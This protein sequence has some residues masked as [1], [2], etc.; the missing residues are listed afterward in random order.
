MP[1][2]TYVRGRETGSVRIFIAVPTYTGGTSAQFLASMVESIPVLDAA[3][4]GWDFCIEEGNC[5]VDDARNSLVRQFLKTD[6]TDL[7]FI[8][9]DVGW[10]ATDLVA[11][12]G[13]DRD[14]VA[15]V[16]PKKQDDP[17]FPVL[18]EGGKSIWSEP[19]GC[20]EVLGA[21]TGFM[22][23]RRGVLEALREAHK[24][25]SF[26]GQG[27]DV[28]DEPYYP[29]FERLISDGKR[30]SGDY[31]FC[32]K[33]KQQG[34]K[35]Y[36]S[37]EMQFTHEGSKVWAGSLGAFW[38][39]A[40]NIENPSLPA[41]FDKLRRDG[42]AQ[43]INDIVKAWDNNF[44]ATSELCYAA[45]EIVKSRGGDVLETGSGISTALLASATSGTVYSLEHDLIYMERTERLLE[46]LKIRNVKLIYAPLKDYGGFKWYSLPETLPAKFSF[47]FCD[48]PQRR[49]GRDGLFNMLGDV[50]KDA[51]ICVD[52]TSDPVVMKTFETWSS[53]NG[54]AVQT[55]GELRQFAVSAPGMKKAA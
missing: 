54:R 48:G 31:A 25:R 11:L 21:P 7:V 17:D 19:D 22:R 10:R 6:C 18:M 13:Y 42:D 20:V 52:D 37:P 16:Y 28:G 1:N 35:I 33:W 8:D 4:I 29:I 9:A 30:R 26:L 38:R 55:L 39:K 51:V 49:Y 41:L 23:I 43:V 40:H 15:G 12:A 47:V 34:G 24:G 2:M 45:L 44:S 46:L 5:H 3:G 36:V 27:A 53:A 32:H 50:I 14:V